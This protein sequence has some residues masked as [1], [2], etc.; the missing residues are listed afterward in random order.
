MLVKSV[1]LLY[2][3][4]DVND[5][6]Q[7]FDKLIE[8]AKDLDLAE[9][10]GFAFWHISYFFLSHFVN[11]FVL[12]VE[13]DTGGEQ[14][15]HLRWVFL[16]DIASFV[17]CSGDDFILTIFYHLVG[18]FYEKTSHFVSRVIKPGDSVYHFDSV[19]EG[20]KSFNY[21]FGSTLVE[22][23]NELF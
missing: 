23:V 4:E 20:G 2:I 10:K 14:N 9:I 21:L 18:D 1:E 19:H 15:D 7:S 6:S 16:P 12:F 3:L 13:F 11:V 17:S 22:R 5:F 8:F